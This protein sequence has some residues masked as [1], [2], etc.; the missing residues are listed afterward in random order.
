PTRKA[1]EK[2]FSLIPAGHKKDRSLHAEGDAQKL[3]YASDT[4]TFERISQV[5]ENVNRDYQFTSL[6]E[7]NAIL[8][9]YNI[10]ADPGRAGSQT[11][12]HG[13]LLYRMLDDQGNTVGPPIKASAFDSKPTLANLEKKFDQHK[14]QRL[15]DL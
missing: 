9:Q 4:N 3:T 14:Q 12:K 5:L 15:A 6:Q 1:I 13:G 2:E 11:R 7:Y 10:L 8:R